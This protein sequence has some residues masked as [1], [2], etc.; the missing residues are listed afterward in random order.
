M[1]I[2]CV[3]NKQYRVDDRMLS[4]V[5]G[6][7]V[8]NRLSIRVR[9]ADMV[10][11]TAVALCL[12]CMIYEAQARVPPPVETPC[13]VVQSGRTTTL[14]SIKIVAV[15]QEIPETYSTSVKNTPSMSWYVS[16][17]YALKTD[18]GEEV[19]RQYLTYAELAYPFHVWI[20][21]RPPPDQDRLRM[22]FVIGS[23]LDKTLDAIQGDGGFRPGSIC[24]GITYW[25]MNTAYNWPSG[26]LQ[27]H[28]RDL[29]I[30]ENLHLMQMCCGSASSPIRLLEGITHTSCNHVYDDEKKQLTLAVFDKPTVNYPTTDQIR[31]IRGEYKTFR[32]ACGAGYGYITLYTSFMW[33]H[34]ERLMKWRLWRDAMQWEGKTGEDMDVMVEIFGNLDGQIEQD[35]KVWLDVRHPTF[36]YLDWGWEQSA[37][38][39][40]SYGWPQQGPYSRTD[41]LLPPGEKPEYDPL[42]MD[43]P[44][45]PMS[46]LVGPVRRGVEDPSV[47]ALVSFARC[48]GYGLGGIGLGVQTERPTSELSYM[49]LL[50]Q[51]GNA[52]LIQ[53]RD[54]GMPDETVAFPE[55]LKKAM[56]TGGHQVGLTAKIG[57]DTLVVTLRA[58]D[59]ATNAPVEFVKSWP[60]NA[61]QCKRLLSCPGTILAKDGYHA[62]TPYFDDARRPE[63]ADLS[64]PAPGNRWRF[65]G[66]EQTYRLYR[67]MSKLKDDSPASLKELA[68]AMVEA[69]DKDLATQAAAMKA[70]ALSFPRVVK[71]IRAV[72]SP[73]TDLA[74]AELAGTSMTLAFDKDATFDKPALTATI[75]APISGRLVGNVSFITA[76]AGVIGP[77]CDTQSVDVV[78]GGA[79]EIA[80]SWHAVTESPAPFTVDVTAHIEWQGST[81]SLSTAI[82]GCPSI[83]R[84]LTIGPFDNNGTMDTVHPPETESFDPQK[85]YTG[86]DGKEISWEKRERLADSP[87]ASEFFLD[88]ASLYSGQN[89]AAYA[90][91]WICSE[92]ETNAT[93][94]LGSDDGIVVWL[95]GERVH[96]NLV[97]RGYLSKQDR[98]PIHLKEGRNKLL[99]KV[100][101]NG[102][103]WGLCAHVLSK[104]SG[105]LDGITYF[106]EN[107][108]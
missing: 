105:R 57:K 2:R 83:P 59:P 67:A 1:I 66:D 68:R 89:V 35:W 32:E 15:G 39:L 17:H 65:E 29:V 33:S 11:M 60:I 101:Q 70:Y 6:N 46:P 37:D 36:H 20:I 103:G 99:I 88:F 24:G 87:L 86:K 56:A 79:G 22:P 82:S 21:G 73:V 12:T 42:C 107:K 3:K 85:K 77:D 48:P 72:K 95:N 14:K 50:I 106:I 43:Y 51:D 96:S 63:A 98:V 19:A 28:K 47:G 18:Q 26:A 44:L 94:A 76:P 54:L 8:N 31:Q 41:I 34:P 100:A 74:L 30:H 9:N 71:D 53:G 45:Q 75:G 92:V 5:H 90:Q 91:T 38:T 7:G 102:G 23:S 40:I 93:L 16:Q 10:V 49:P 69:M 81:F 80:W 78:A 108:K 97:A 13:E 64:L 84:W 55:D 25:G 27:Y 104:D 61:E 52:L 62:I 4:Q 58:Q